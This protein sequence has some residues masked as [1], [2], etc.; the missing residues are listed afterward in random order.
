MDVHN[1]KQFK[2]S[3]C[4]YATARKGH[5]KR[6]MKTHEPTPSHEPVTRSRKPSEISFTDGSD[7]DQEEDDTVETFF[8]DRQLRSSSRTT[9][10][11]EKGESPHVE[12]KSQ[13]TRII[14]EESKGEL[15]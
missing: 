6:H 7:Y 11:I 13:F 8:V 4:G 9:V 14:E 2:C 5:L 1:Y 12:N 15:S 10:S 3:L